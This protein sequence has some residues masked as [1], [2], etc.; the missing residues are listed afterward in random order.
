MVDTGSPGNICGSEWSREHEAESIRHGFYPEY[1]KR[2][3]PMRCSGVGTGSQTADWNV[4][5]RICLGTGDGRIDNYEA[6]ELPD[7]K[8]P[9]LLG[10]I[11]MR[12]LRTL[13]DTFS[14]KMYLVGPG[15]YEIRLS[16]GSEMLPLE[17]SPMGHLM[18]PCSRFEQSNKRRQQGPPQPAVSFVVGDYYAATS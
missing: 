17:E 8:T 10:Q 5:H 3:K 7:S 13:I 12:K 6:P 14:H 2:D 11:S 16:P 9:A 4:R 15:G 18:L 1:T